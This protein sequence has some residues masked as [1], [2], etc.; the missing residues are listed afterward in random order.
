MK[1]PKLLEVFRLSEANVTS[2]SQIHKIP[3]WA[4]ERINGYNRE[5]ADV[6]AKIV[7]TRFRREWNA[8]L[9]NPDSERHEPSCID[10]AVHV[11][12]VQA[13]ATHLLNRFFGE[14]AGRIVG[15]LSI[16]RGQN[17]AAVVSRLMEICDPS[18]DDDR[19]HE[20]LAKL[21][22]EHVKIDPN[23]L[24][25]RA[26]IKFPDGFFWV[27]LNK[28]ECSQE[29]NFMQHCGNGSGDLYS[30]RDPNGKPHVTVDVIHTE[31]QLYI[32]QIRGKQNTFPDRKYWDH[33]KKFVEHMK[34]GAVHDSIPDEFRA[35]IIPH[36]N[37]K[38]ST[39]ELKRILPKEDWEYYNDSFNGDVTFQKI[40]DLHAGLIGMTVPPDELRPWLPPDFYDEDD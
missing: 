30:L 40:Y 14:F 12:D 18:N 17:K 24:R 8:I 38:P 23:K 3:L 33:V 9:K 4:A 39:D 34:I 29:G 7:S 6:L 16:S 37:K 25:K 15:I 21:Y 19:L 32:N 2:L 13:P 10:C 27:K 22:V 35:H 11:T 1:A 5:F 20:D 26:V 31:S 28:D 36:Q